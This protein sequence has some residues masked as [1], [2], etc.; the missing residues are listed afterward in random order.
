MKRMSTQE[1]ALTPFSK[2]VLGGF[3]S[4]SR[5]SVPS[6]VS[7]PTAT[8]TAVA[9]PLT[10]LLPRNARSA[11]SV[12]VPAACT[13]PPVFSTGSLSPVRAD[14]LTN[15]SRA[16]R[17]R[18]S[19]GIMSPALKCTT[20]PTTTSSSGISA[21]TQARSTQA[22]VCSMLPSRAATLPLR[23][24]CT[25]RSSPETSTIVVMMS[26]VAKLSS[27]GA[28]KMISVNTEIT[29]SASSTA[30]KGLMKARNKRRKSGSV[31]PLGRR[32]AP[33]SSR[34]RRTAASSSPPAAEPSSSSRMSPSAAAASSSRRRRASALSFSARRTGARSVLNRN[35][36]ASYLPL[37]FLHRRPQHSLKRAKKGRLSG[38]KLPRQGGSPGKKSAKNQR[39]GRV[40]PQRS[41]DHRM[42]LVLL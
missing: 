30:V 38:G 25:K 34:A 20:S 24:S 10:T 21:R 42:M 27:P 9:K 11:A 1:T 5:A 7:A 28:A 40:R 37:L 35:F 13:G 39:Y 19:A 17:M 33:C 41:R 2:V 12:G 15:R 4:S 26:T 18:T 22:V 16:V 14:W 6:M 32:F 23:V 8:T 29:A 36:I 31:L 3:S